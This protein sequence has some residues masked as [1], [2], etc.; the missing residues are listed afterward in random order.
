ME[1]WTYSKAISYDIWYFY[2]NT[3]NMSSRIFYSISILHTFL[4]LFGIQNCTANNNKKSAENPI[5]DTTLLAKKYNNIIFY[6]CF[7]K[8]KFNKIVSCIKNKN[9]YKIFAITE[10]EFVTKRS[11]KEV[12]NSRCR[13]RYFLIILDLTPPSFKRP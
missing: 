13:G 4:L 12:S 8:S 7:L 2:Q 10:F 6:N 11:Y 9:Y 1:N 3:F 5:E